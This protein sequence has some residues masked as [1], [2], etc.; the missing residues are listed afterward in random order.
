MVGPADLTIPAQPTIS[1]KKD[2]KEEKLLGS[3][4]EKA[5][6]FATR[7]RPMNSVDGREKL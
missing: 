2:T 4:W 3:I 6:S 5:R 7:I 1:Q